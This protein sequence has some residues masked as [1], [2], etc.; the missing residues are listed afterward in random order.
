[1]EKTARTRFKDM[2]IVSKDSWRC[3]ACLYCT[4]R[5]TSQESVKYYLARKQLWAIQT[6]FKWF[7]LVTMRMSVAFAFWKWSKLVFTSTFN[8]VVSKRKRP[9]MLIMTNKYSWRNWD[10]RKSLDNQETWIIEVRILEVGLELLWKRLSFPFNL[11]FLVGLAF[12]PMKYQHC[13][14]HN[15]IYWDPNSAYNICTPNFES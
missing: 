2:I 5:R 6:S 8:A 3:V 4:P 11:L 14:I 1:M 15:T 12:F 7:S 10:Q 9:R 13:V